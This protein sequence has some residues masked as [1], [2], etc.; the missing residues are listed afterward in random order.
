[1]LGILDSV[2]L[3][4]LGVEF[5]DESVLLIPVV[6]A[7]LGTTSVIL[8]LNLNYASSNLGVFGRHPFI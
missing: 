3:I 5:V 8:L 4:N 6:I 7:D 1:M 2:L